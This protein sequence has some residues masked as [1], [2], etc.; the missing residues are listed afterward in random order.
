MTI[1]PHILVVEDE[2]RWREEIFREALENEG[3]QVKTSSNYSEAIAALDQ[4]AFD[5]AVI[6]IN[7]TGDPGNQDGIRVLEQMAALGHRTLAIVVSGSPTRAMSKDNVQKFQPIAFVDK[8]EFDI[9]Q[10]VTMVIGALPL[11]KQA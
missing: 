11:P 4:Q 7:L 1:Q 2:E 10:F 6:D 3:Y 9:A 5:L 8:T